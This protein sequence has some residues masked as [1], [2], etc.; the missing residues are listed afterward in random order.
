MALPHP[1]PF[2]IWEVPVTAAKTAF[3]L[4]L[5]RPVFIGE[6][7]RLKSMLTG[8]DLKD[9]ISELAKEEASSK[10]FFPF[11]ERIWISEQGA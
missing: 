10:I 11:M 9:I 2:Q 3:N 7:H 6:L 1:N 8:E 4:V 5:I